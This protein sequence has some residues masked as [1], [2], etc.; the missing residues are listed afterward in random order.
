MIYLQTIP[1]DVIFNILRNFIK[2]SK[3]RK[4]IIMPDFF[5]FFITAFLLSSKTLIKNLNIFFINYLQT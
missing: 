3:I 1:N 4:K 5:S 2:S